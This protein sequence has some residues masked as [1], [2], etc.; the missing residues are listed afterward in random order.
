[1]K[2]TRFLVAATSGFLLLAGTSAVQAQCEIAKV[3][4]SDAA[5]GDR[6]GFSVAISGDFAVVGAHQHAGKGAGYVF[7]REGLDWVEVTTL[8]PSGVTIASGDE[9]GRS[10]AIDGNVAV[11]GASKHD[12]SMPDAGAAYVFRR[13][14]GGTW[15]YEAEL[16][17]SDAFFEDEFGHSVAVAGDEILVGAPNEDGPASVKDSGTVYVFKYNGVDSWVFE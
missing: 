3:T 10:V 11:V 8:Q 15:Q 17:A 13:D 9:Y 2:S 1:M 14:A 6:F 12:T 7:E 16:T 5:A 4:P